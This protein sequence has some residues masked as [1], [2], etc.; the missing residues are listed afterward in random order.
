[1]TTIEETITHSD[2]KMTDGIHALEKDLSAIRTGKASSSLVENVIVKYY[3]TS[4]RLRDIAGISIPEPRTIVI[5][6][7]DKNAL[8]DIEKALLAC[9]LGVTPLNDGKVI[10]LQLPELSEER[11][12]D[13]VKEVKKRAEE[14]RVEIRTFRRESNDVIKKLQKDGKITEDD[15]AKALEKIQKTTDDHISLINKLSDNKEAELLHI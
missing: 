3:G 11:R 2:K 7:W 9:N 10:R 8:P 14:A 6:P 1:M 4:T 15:L 5:L 13:Y 12:R